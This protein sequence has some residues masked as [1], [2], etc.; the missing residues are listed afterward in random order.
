LADSHLRLEQQGLS[1]ESPFPA[2]DRTPVK[3][4]TD[5]RRV[6]SNRYSIFEARYLPEVHSGLH[7]AFRAA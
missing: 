7:G 2:R 5:D 6:L 3:V 4:W 1:A